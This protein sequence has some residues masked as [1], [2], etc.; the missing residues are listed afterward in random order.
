M[1][2]FFICWESF[3]IRLQFLLHCLDFLEPEFDLCKQNVVFT[4]TVSINLCNIL[5]DGV[6]ISAVY[7]DVVNLIF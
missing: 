1:L 3:N 2:N 4:I 7:T 6:A 5:H